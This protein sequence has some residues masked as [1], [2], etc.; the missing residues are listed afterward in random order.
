MAS[1]IGVNILLDHVRDYPRLLAHLKAVQPSMI[2]A[3]LDNAGENGKELARVAALRRELP[4]TTVIGRVYYAQDGGMHTKPKAEGDTNF[5]VV[6][7]QNAINAWGD[8]G[9]NGGVLYVTNEPGTDID[10]AAMTRLVNWTREAIL[11]ANTQGV[12]LCVLNLATGHPKLVNGEWDKRFDPILELL[13]IHRQHMVGLHEYKP[14]AGQIGRVHSLI[15]RCVTKGIPVPQIAITEAGWDKGGVDPKVNGYR[16]RGISGEAFARQMADVWKGTY[17]AHP[18]IIGMAVFCYGDNGSWSA[19]NVEGDSAFFDELLRNPTPTPL[20]APIPVPVPL[21]PIVTPPTQPPKPPADHA[22][23]II[24]LEAVDSTLATR[25]DDLKQSREQQLI[26][27]A[28]IEAELRQV[29]ETRQR[30]CNVI[31]T[32]KAA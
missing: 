25:E 23:Q 15:G 27:L 2:V 21:P 7:P 5:Y 10:D 31:T 26:T 28:R 4:H 20:P 18:E 1:K 32:L 3:T 11:Y 8:L 14:D 16:S 12:R 30:L 13:S 9:R 22:A 24:E 17:A 29:Q 19:F 6:S